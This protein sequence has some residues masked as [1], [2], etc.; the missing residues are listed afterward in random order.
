MY[1]MY[2]WTYIC[3]CENE[4]VCVSLRVTKGPDKG[5]GC[6]PLSPSD[7]SFEVESLLKPRTHIILAKLEYNK[8][9]RS[10]CFCLPWELLGLQTCTGHLACY[11]SA[12]IQMLVFMILQQALLPT[13]LSLHPSLTF[14]TWAL[15]E[16]NVQSL[17]PLALLLQIQPTTDKKLSGK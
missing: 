16:D 2:V 4:E 17:G 8:A 13:E 9:Q 6:L 10:S 14:Y 12:G 7:C 1:C 11:F 15:K 5:D 3:M